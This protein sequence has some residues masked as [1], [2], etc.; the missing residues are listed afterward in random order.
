MGVKVKGL[1]LRGQVWWFRPAQQNGL[2]PSPFSLDT[3]DENT[4][5]SKVMEMRQQP[6]FHSP[7]TWAHE[8]KL[9][10]DEALRLKRISASFAPTRRMTLRNFGRDYKVTRPEAVTASLMQRYYDDQ[11]DA[12]LKSNTARGYVT[13]LRAFFKWLMA[14]GRLRA[15]PALGV[16]MKRD[17]RFYHHRFCPKEEMDALIDNCP[18]DDVKFVLLCGFDA[19]LRRDEISE[20]V[21]A[22]FATQGIVHLQN[23][24]HYEVKDGD[25][26]HIPLTDRFAAFLKTFDRRGPY[27]LHPEVG[28]SATSEANYRYDFRRPFEEYLAALSK[29]ALPEFGNQVHDFTWITSQTMRH[30][31]AS[32]RVQKGVSIYKVARWLGDGVEVVQR[33]YG[34]L[35]PQADKDIEV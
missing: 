2:R 29:K 16:K 10:M 17:V 33:H 5:V 7:A 11:L 6:D 19:G 12:G 27:M 25:A 15:N 30:T 1:Y 35:A 20:A 31:F 22:W 24:A 18:R 28:R 32:L 13:S 4:A 34:H 23:S 14:E 21:P 8:V 3:A 9:Y 26:R